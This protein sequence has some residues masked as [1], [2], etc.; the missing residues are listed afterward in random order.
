MRRIIEMS[1]SIYLY[2]LH[3][4][5]ILMIVIEQGFQIDR[6]RPLPEKSDSGLDLVPTHLV[7]FPN[8]LDIGSGLGERTPKKVGFQL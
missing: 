6:P 8:P 4:S 1:A 2:I 5:M 7:R 3:P